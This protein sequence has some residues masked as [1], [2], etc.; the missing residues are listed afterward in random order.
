MDALMY[1][2][3]EIKHQIPYEILHAAMYQGE[4]PY[5]S[6]LTTL[7]D[8]IMTKVIKKRV[9][10]TANVIG[11]VETLIPLNHITPS[12]YETLYTVYEI[13]PELTG[14]REIVSALNLCYMPGN[15]FMG[16]TS[17][18]TGVGN[19]NSTHAMSSSSM[20]PV[21]NVA[22]RVGSSFSMSGVL[23]NAHL[24]IVARNT[25]AVYAN[26]RTLA[27]FGMRVVV[28]NDSR[29]SN[30]QPRSYPHLAKLCVLATKAYIY[31][32]LSI[33]INSGVLSGGQELGMF[34]TF[35]ENYADAQEQYEVYLT[36][37]WGQVAFMN[38]NT[39]YSSFL[40]SM[41]APD[42]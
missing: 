19:V 8:K 9:L 39:R 34:K 20:N 33:A 16:L 4:D 5:L 18:Y 21:M 26:Y 2:I 42:L 37:K 3:N 30:I 10:L 28:E 27:N 24:E 38:D 22:S 32:T 25:V 17:G 11:G 29:L 15:G 14:R 40:S 23:T 35:V 6:S 12:F 1:C 31:N 36:E 13:P 41:I 7:E